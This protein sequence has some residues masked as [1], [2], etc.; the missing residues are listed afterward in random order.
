MDLNDA[1]QIETLLDHAIDIEKEAYPANDKIK[2][3]FVDAEFDLNS[4]IQNTKDLERRKKV[5][6]VEWSGQDIIT[7]LEPLKVNII[8]N[9]FNQIK[10]FRFGSFRPIFKVQHYLEA[11]CLHS[12]FENFLTLCVFLNTLILAIDHYG[13]DEGLEK[14]FNNMNLAFTIIF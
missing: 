8:M 2:D 9:S 13:I 1:A 5:I 12:A 3:D 14:I 7:E 10:V 11:F 6:Q 4:A